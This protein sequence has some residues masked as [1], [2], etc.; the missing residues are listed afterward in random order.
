VAARILF[1]KFTRA[2]PSPNYPICRL[3]S[4]TGKWELGLVPMLFG[5]RVRAGL[6]GAEWCDIDY[7]AGADQA[8]QV[9]LLITVLTILESFPESITSSELYKRMPGF[10][11]KPINQDPCWGQLQRMAREAIVREQENEL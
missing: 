2:E 4:E 3:I 9:E 5:V 11:R 1:M 7:C 6:N 8:F 10:K